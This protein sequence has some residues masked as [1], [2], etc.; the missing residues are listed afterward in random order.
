MDNT[1][2]VSI[3]LGA[4]LASG[5]RSVLANAE[6]STAQLGQILTTSSDGL[7]FIKRALN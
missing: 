7:Y 3:V 2:A 5:F 6:K 4:A 1:F